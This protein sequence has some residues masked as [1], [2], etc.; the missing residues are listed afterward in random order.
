M[1]PDS[2]P[3]HEAL[4]RR[5]N[6][7]LYG[8]KGWMKFLAVLMIIYGVLTAL[9]IVGLLVAWLPVWMGVLLWQAAGAAEEAQS[10]GDTERFL[11][12]QMK[13]KTYFVLSGVVALILL[14]L[15]VAQFGLMGTA[16]LM[17]WGEMG[18]VAP[19]AQ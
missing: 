18:Q 8:A 15:F 11:Q 13:L 10:S 3:S 17:H 4:I 9:T 1:N 6:T 5:L 19:P 7:P 16:M 12:A 2:R 14:I